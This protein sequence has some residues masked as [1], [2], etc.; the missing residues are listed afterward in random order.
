MFG[1]YN[2]GGKSP[3][4][5]KKGANKMRKFKVLI[6]DSACYV[7]EDEDNELTEADA[8]R[9]AEEWFIEREPTIYVEELEPSSF[10]SV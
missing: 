10:D 2:K 7:V 9:I 5:N 4:I 1:K 8:L 3:P 6:E